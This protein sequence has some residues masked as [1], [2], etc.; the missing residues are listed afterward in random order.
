VIAADLLPPLIDDVPIKDCDPLNLG[1]LEQKPLRR[2]TPRQL[3]ERRFRIA[4]LARRK[5]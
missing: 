3:A 1:L 5:K 4:C 2:L